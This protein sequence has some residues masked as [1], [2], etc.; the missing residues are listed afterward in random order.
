MTPGIGS[1][2]WWTGTVNTRSGN[3]RFAHLAFFNHDEEDGAR[4]DK[5]D[6]RSQVF[7]QAKVSITPRDDVF[8]TFEDVRF[9]DGQSAAVTKSSARV[10][11]ASS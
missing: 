10:S 4:P 11:M 6:T 9:D 2:G 7:V 5:K 3:Q 1:D 8:V